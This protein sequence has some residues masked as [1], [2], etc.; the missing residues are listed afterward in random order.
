MPDFGQ[1]LYQWL[2]PISAR[3]LEKAYQTSKKA[4]EIQ[5]EYAHYPNLQA[6][7]K[8]SPEHAAIY[9]EATLS[10]HIWWITCYLVIVEMNRCLVPDSFLQ[11]H[12]FS[13]S[14]EANQPNLAQPN[15][16]PGQNDEMHRERKLLWIKTTLQDLKVSKSIGKSAYRLGLLGIPEVQKGFWPP[17]V[18]KKDTSS[19][20]YE[21]IGLVPRSI[22]RTFSRFQ[23]EVTGQLPSLVRPEFRFAKYQALASLQY[24][25]CLVLLPWTAGWLW[26][27]WVVQWGP[28]IWDTANHNFFLTLS[29]E[30]RALKQ[31]EAQ[32]ALIWLD[33]LIGDDLNQNL[34]AEMHSRTMNFL[35]LYQKESM[36]NFAHLSTDLVY[37]GTIVTVLW[38][39]QKRLAVLNSWAQELF[40]SLSD[41][42]KAFWVLLLT[43]L[44]IGFHSPHGWEV[45]IGLVFDH[46]GLSHSPQVISCFVST[47]PV[48][49]DTVCKYWI[50]RH[51]N[52]ISPSIVVSYHAMNE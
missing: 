8:F 17:Q 37:F 47:F 35:T 49:L 13:S 51:L 30:I 38:V 6:A 45:L 5:K 28:L 11:H 42:M 27:Q 21:A 12:N 43:D 19:T 50:F 16:P 31:L 2:T 14:P 36:Q 29:Q 10:Q 32:E 24:I 46:F 48:I 44:C 52:R 3:A 39:G 15:F 22:T 41:T 9:I 7:S 40:Y 4:R 23:S 18:E 25:A 34:T 33:M 26:T 1:W 20:A